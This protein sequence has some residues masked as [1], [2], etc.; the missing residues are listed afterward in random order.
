MIGVFASVVGGAAFISIPFI[1]W[2]YPQATVGA[3]VGNLKV[4]GFFR[5]IGSTL[6]T[7][8]DIAFIENFKLVPAAFLGT[9]A[10]A[11]LIAHIDEKWMLPAIVMAILFTV[12][13]PK[14]A[15]K[16]TTKMFVAASFL[17]GVYSGVLGAG[18]G[19]M[20]VALLRL[21]HPEDSKIAYVKIQAR[22]VEFLLMTTAV[23]VHAASGNL[24]AA[25]WVPLSVGGFIG[26][27]IGGN[28]LRV[29]EELS[30]LWQKRILY[31]AFAVDLFVATKKF[32]E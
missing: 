16:V 28:A 25:L 2:C 32:F 3:V 23:F 7:Y 6:S 12:Q 14:L 27:Y 20:L 21:K 30:G 19:V 8:K 29:M 5:S 22:F 13:A 24:N 15:T 18:Q 1:Q 31:T 11:L 10:G 9:V 4:G 17:T 26:G